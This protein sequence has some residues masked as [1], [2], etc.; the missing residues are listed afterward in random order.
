MIIESMVWLRSESIDAA[1]GANELNKIMNETAEKFKQYETQ[2]TNHMNNNDYESAKTDIIGM[3]YYDKAIKTINDKLVPS[4]W[5][6]VFMDI[7]PYL[8]CYE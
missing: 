6:S 8:F 3:K 2:F 7:Y 5:I 1:K 4:I